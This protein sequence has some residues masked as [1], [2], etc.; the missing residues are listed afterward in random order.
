MIGIDC[1][2]IIGLVVV[3]L[4]ASSSVATQSQ[5]S[6][7]N[8]SI[9]D[10][11]LMEQVERH[12]NHPPSSSAAELRNDILACQSDPCFHGLCIDHTNK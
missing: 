3:F 4:T 6:D 8:N 10:P 5:S 12:Y 11:E 9:T 2:V 1:S 7:G